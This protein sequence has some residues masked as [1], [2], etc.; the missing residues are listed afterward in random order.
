MLPAVSS[1]AGSRAARRGSS[2]L[3]GE[4]GTEAWAR[5]A[6][7]M[8]LDGLAGT[9]ASVRIRLEPALLPVVPGACAA[10]AR[11]GCAAAL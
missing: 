3:C 7:G 6:G 4:G 9:A 2:P 10:A 11:L 5:P 1:A 8:R